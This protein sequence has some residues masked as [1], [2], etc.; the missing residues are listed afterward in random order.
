MSKHKNQS[1]DCKVNSRFKITLYATLMLA[2]LS[3]IICIDF[4]WMNQQIGYCSLNKIFHGII[5]SF[6]NILVSV[7]SIFMVIIAYMLYKMYKNQYNNFTSISFS[8]NLNNRYETLCDLRAMKVLLW[9]LTPPMFVLIFC[10]VIE[11]YSNQISF[12]N[13]IY[14]QNLTIVCVAVETTVLSL[15]FT[16]YT[17]QVRKCV[18]EMLGCF[19]ERSE[20]KITVATINVKASQNINLTIRNARQAADDLVNDWITTEKMLSLKK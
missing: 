17:P 5:N 4:D 15:M 9:L 8:H 14:T 2:F 10:H 16:V 18:F 7:V 6:V 3:R 11:L 12:W 19:K 13:E 1:R 20:T